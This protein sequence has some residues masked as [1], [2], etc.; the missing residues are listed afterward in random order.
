MIM[1]TDMTAT[2]AMKTATR[3]TKRAM[4]VTAHQRQHADLKE[5][6]HVHLQ[7]RQVKN[8]RQ[9]HQW[10]H[11]RYLQQS[12]RTRHRQHR[13]LSLLRDLHPLQ[14]PLMPIIGH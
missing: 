8:Q 12:L 11:H 2:K 5:H 4:K 1:T 13:L 6:Q 7:H 3:A 14:L 10:E 9:D